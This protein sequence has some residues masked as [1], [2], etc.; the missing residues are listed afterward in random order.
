MSKCAG[1]RYLLWFVVIGCLLLFGSSSL[2][3]FA[4]AAGQGPLPPA[5]LGD[6]A[7]SAS[8]QV[9][10]PGSEALNTQWTFTG[11]VRDSEG[12]APAD[13]SALRI[14][15]LGGTADG[16]RDFLWGTTVGSD[17]VFVAGTDVLFSHYYL[18]ILTTGS[19]YSAISARPGS[20]GEALDADLIRYENVGPGQYGDNLFVVGSGEPVA[21]RTSTVTP[22]ATPAPL[23][24]NTPTSTRTRTPM[25]TRTRT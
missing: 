11:Y 19:P 25:P 13:V 17:G 5:V 14:M 2:A 23:P 21:T 7:D 1:R 24:S 10:A 8:W 9:R 3:T 22:T 12:A 18:R 6:S 4:V 20:G 15:L 16:P